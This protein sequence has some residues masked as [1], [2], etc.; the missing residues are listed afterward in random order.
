MTEHKKETFVL[1]HSAWLGAW[2]WDSVVKSLEG[3]GHKVLAPDLPG[4]GSKKDIHEPSMMDYVDTIIK[5]LDS[6]SDPVI[7]VGHS[8]NGITISQVAELRPENVKCLV[9]LAGFLLQNNGSFFNAVQAVDGS[10]AVE[11]FYLSADEKHALVHG[12]AMQD[13]FA[14]D[15]PK[16]AFIGAIP[17]MVP[18]PVEPLAYK[19]KLS[20]ERFGAIPKYYIECTEDRAVPIGVQRS[21]YQGK[22]EQ[23][24]TI[25][26]SHTP[27]FSQPDTVADIL[28]TIA[29]LMRNDE[30][31]N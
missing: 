31:M 23:V 26:S 30:T 5:V 25:K 17:L 13:A 12:E 8:F 7:L 24:F 19:L 4:H 16:E 27:N 10:V 28:E 18:E 1:I 29:V 11:N 6:I 2:Q 9:Y 15:I 3:A 14:H 22:V 21:M 20:E